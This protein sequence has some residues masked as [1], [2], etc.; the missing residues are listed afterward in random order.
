[1]IFLPRLAA[2]VGI[3]AGAVIYIQMLDQTISSTSADN[4]STKS[5]A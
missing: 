4:T 5:I 3:A 2:S 1:V